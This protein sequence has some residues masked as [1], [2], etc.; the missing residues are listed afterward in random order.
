[1]Q[2][3]FPL[4][5]KIQSNRSPA[6]FKVTERSSEVFVHEQTGPIQPVL[7]GTEEDLVSLFRRDWPIW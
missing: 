1:M 7:R 5:F 6:T 4:P 2:Y 3:F